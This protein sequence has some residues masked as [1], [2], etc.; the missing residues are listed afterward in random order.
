VHPIRKAVI[1]AAGLGTRLLPWTKTVP[2]ELLPILDRPAIH[3]VVE[4]AVEAGVEEVILVSAPGKDAVAA[5]FDP[6][7]EL[8]R[9]L[10]RRGRTAEADEL[11]R[12]STLCEI[13]VVRQHEPLGL[14]HAVARARRLVG[15]EPFAVLLPD[16]LVDAQPGALA[17]LVRQWQGDPLLAVHPV[18]PEEV[19]RY[20]VIRPDPD[21]DGRIL[22][23][24]EKPAPG[25]A[26]SHLALTGRYLLDA[27]VFDALA[28]TEPGAGGEIQLTDAIRLLLA[29]GRTV[30]WATFDGVPYDLG[31]VAGFLAANAAL[32]A[33]R[34]LVAPVLLGAAVAR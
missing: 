2:K 24:V 17:Q 22:D 19:G 13:H 27:D 31:H 34:G 33:R 11:R 1:P 14:G 23:L 4:E 18:D 28:E 29:A 9:T 32:A 26:P 25:C 12:L 3:Y 6:A 30:R 8:E 20:G 10:R 21:H 5:Y 7:P 16:V 15:E